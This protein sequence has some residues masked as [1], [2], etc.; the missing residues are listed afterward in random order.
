MGLD[1]FLAA[2]RL[3][4]PRFPEVRFVMVGQSDD[5]ADEVAKECEAS[6]GRLILRRNSPYAD[7]PNYYRLAS[8]VVV[9]TRGDRT[10][11]SLAAMEAMATRKAVAGFAIG[12]IPEIVEHEKTG[13][14]VEPEDV[15]ALADAISRLLEDEP[16]RT[17]LAEAAYRE[18]Q[19]SFDENLVNATMEHH[20]TDA[21]SA[22]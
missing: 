17:R 1:S 20:F 16:L 5:L 7:L 8:I 3:T 4:A 19:V 11:S 14:L 6:D 15:Q 12:G 2:A 21:L 9:P 18:S 13:L 22:A 10:C